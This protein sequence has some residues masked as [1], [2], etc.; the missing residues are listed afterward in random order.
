MKDVRVDSDG[1]LRCW[2]CG[3]K[4]FLAKRTGRAHV[5]A[6]VTAGVGALA[7]KKKLKCQLCGEYNQ[8]GDAKPFNGPVNTKYRAQWEKEQR[9]AQ[10]LTVFRTTPPPASPAQ[11]TEQSVAD[12][13]TKLAKLRDDGV[14]TGTSFRLGRPSC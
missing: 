2:N 12:E 6:Y 4:N 10:P 7:T 13:I 3:G 11:A 1:E 5:V 8:V 9:V 14:L